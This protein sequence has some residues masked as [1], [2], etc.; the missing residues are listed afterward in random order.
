MTAMTYPQL[1][2]TAPEQ[3]ELLAMP[4]TPLAPDQVAG[5]TIDG[6][7]AQAGAHP[8]APQSS[9]RSPAGA[10]FTSFGSKRASVATRSRWARI[11]SWMS[12]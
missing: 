11:T 9:G 7:S 3:I 12:L 6:H 8:L 4:R 1:A 5:P 2:V 10:I